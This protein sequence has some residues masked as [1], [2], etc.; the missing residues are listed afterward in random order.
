MEGV[1]DL[2]T[3]T[4]AL[5]Q[6][7]LHHLED[8]TA[9]LLEGTVESHNELEPAV[10]N[11]SFRIFIQ[12]PRSR[13]IYIAVDR[14]ASRPLLYRIEGARIRFASTLSAFP[15]P[16]PLNTAAFA[17]MLSSGFLYGDDTWIDGVRWLPGGTMLLVEDRSWRI[18]RYWDYKLLPDEETDEPALRSRLAELLITAVERRTRRCPNLGLLLSGGYDSRAILGCCMRLGR[19]VTCLSWSAVERGG[20]D[21]S[22]A[23]ELSRRAGVSFRQLSYEPIEIREAITKTVAPFD[24]MRYPIQ[25]ANAFVSLRNVVTHILV[26]DEAFGWNATPISS[27][28]ESL[29]TVGIRRLRRQACWQKFLQPRLRDSL[30]AASDASLARLYTKTAHIPDLHD[31]KDYL[32]VTERLPR[33][34]LPGRLFLDKYAEVL[35]PWLDNDIMDFVARLPRRH[36]LGKALFRATVRQ[37]FPE[38]FA[39]PMANTRLSI[40]R[41]LPTT[42]GARTEELFLWSAMYSALHSEP[43]LE[44]RLV[45]AVFSIQNEMGRPAARAVY[46]FLAKISGVATATRL[47][48]LDCLDAIVRAELVLFMVENLSLNPGP[49]LSAFLS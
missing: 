2:E 37:T 47:G 11:G 17:A 20:D 40:E 8:G 49:D 5:S 22:V 16:H 42:P 21:L 32:Y 29:Y 34:V 6:G 35:N 36:R 27:E 30:C 23:R 19:K 43:S 3:S 48:A 38:L 39:V 15:S 1:I 18:E 28:D 33:N 44:A 24:G 4:C 10:L 26:G 45:R 46:S 12:Q 41:F 9:F 25:E 7:N 31:K 13:R 14:L